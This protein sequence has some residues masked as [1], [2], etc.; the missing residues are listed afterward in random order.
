[1]KTVFVVGL[2]ALLST[3]NLCAKAIEAYVHIE[4]FELRFEMV[5]PA[6][7]LSPPS[8]NE[9]NQ[10]LRQQLL[11]RWAAE[12][13]E[14]AEIQSDDAI[15]DFEMDRVEFVREAPKGVVPDDRELIPIEEALVGIVFVSSQD[16]FPEE[17]KLTWKFFPLIGEESTTVKFEAAGASDQFQKELTFSKEDR[18]QEWQLPKLR[19]PALKSTEVATDANWRRTALW[20]F[21]FLLLACGFVVLGNKAPSFQ[22]GAIILASLCVVVVAFA[23]FLARIDYRNAV[24]AAMVSGEDIVHNLL[25]NVY[26]AFDFRQESRIYDTL[27]ASVDGDLL[28]SL[29]LEIREGLA[30]EEE[31]GPRVRITRVRLNECA[32]ER[33]ADVIEAEADWTAFGNVSHWGH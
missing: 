15:V 26:H 11:D 8:N 20:G 1:M 3:M 30:I 6:N 21:I 12:L 31:G 33:N 24:D 9:I 27:A 16:R 10:S 2:F 14:A 32:A 28:E 7:Q 4:P 13:S 25:D 29:Y 19:N 22:R 5:V 17:I 18:V 23:A